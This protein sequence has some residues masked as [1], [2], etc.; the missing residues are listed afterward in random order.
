MFEFMVIKPTYIKVTAISFKNYFKL[1]F[2][3]LIER[4]QFEITL[5]NVLLHKYKYR[6]MF[7]M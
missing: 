5:I 1:Q 7:V 2:Y 4:K 3:V 6:A